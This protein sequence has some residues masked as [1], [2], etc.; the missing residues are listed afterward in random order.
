MF[1]TYYIIGIIIVI[2]GATSNLYPEPTILCGDMIGFWETQANF[3]LKSVHF[4]QYSVR[5]L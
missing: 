4:D 1:L 5:H 3:A 2:I